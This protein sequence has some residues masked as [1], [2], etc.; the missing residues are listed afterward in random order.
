MKELR[1]RVLDTDTLS[2]YH[3]GHPE[4]VARYSSLPVTLR[5]ITVVTVEEVLRGRFA[6]INQAK[7][8]QKIILAYDFLRE[9]VIKFSRIRILRFDESAAAQY[10]RIKHL[11]TRVGTLDLRIAAIALANDGILISA[12]QRHFGQIPSLLTEDWTIA[13]LQ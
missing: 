1:L 9:A 4:V 10:D 11:K 12:N 2:A 5:A 7:N 13:P 3:R 8:L 6:Q